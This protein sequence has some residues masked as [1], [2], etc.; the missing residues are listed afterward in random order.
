MASKADEYR[1]RAAEAERNA[2]ATSDAQ[3]RRA[4]LRL[5]ASYKELAELAERGRGLSS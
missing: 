1:N 4:Y 5:A 3:A 2:E